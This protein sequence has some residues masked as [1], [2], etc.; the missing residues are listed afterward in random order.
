MNRLR[1]SN[2]QMDDETWTK[3]GTAGQNLGPK[4]LPPPVICSMHC[5]YQQL[6]RMKKL[7][8]FL[9]EVQVSLRQK[10][11]TSF[12]SLTSVAPVHHP[13]K[14]VTRLYMRFQF[15]KFPNEVNGTEVPLFLKIH[16]LELSSEP[17]RIRD[18]LPTSTGE[19][20]EMAHCQVTFVS[21]R[22]GPVP[23]TRKH[24]DTRAR[25][26]PWEPE[27]PLDLPLQ[28]DAADQADERGRSVDR[29]WY[30]NGR[31]QEKCSLPNTNQNATGKWMVGRLVCFWEGLFLGG[32]LSC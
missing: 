8:S 2:Q 15:K 31:V 23:K 25:L 9:L 21:F 30:P 28:G 20:F 32:E 17:K 10:V 24:P 13:S 11:V 12:D 5:K 19:R 14:A 26:V 6:A 4:I 3:R 16:I 1:I 27:G 18:K 22:E 7:H 29:C